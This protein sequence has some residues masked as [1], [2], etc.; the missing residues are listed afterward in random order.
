[1]S[2]GL[3]E[4]YGPRA[5]ILGA[6][7][8]LGVSFAEQLA[9]QGFDLTMVARNA[10]RLEAAAGQIRA[11]YR[12]DVATAVLDLTGDDIVARAD[13][14]IGSAEFGLVIYNAG[15]A[16]GI[17]SFIDGPLDRAMHLVKL[18][19]VAPVAFAHRALK[20]MRE[21]GRG[22]F[23]LMSSMSALAGSGVLAAYSGSKA[24]ET[25]FF[26]GLHWEMAQSGVDTLCVVAGLMDTPSMA[27]SG[28]IEGGAGG[29]VP[30]NPDGVAADA[31]KQLGH[32]ATIY[33][34][35]DAVIAAM[36]SAPRDGLVDAMT[37]QGAAL[38]G[39]EL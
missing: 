6:S 31:L 28:V 33:T 16:H 19:C 32:K 15:S 4:R 13:A 17:G 2:G 1:M 11:R 8:G 10:E 34:A 5:L 18:N 35:D 39:V 25:I 23:I 38:W 22:G 27:R 7:E 29:H 26:E 21:R 3:Y 12:V 9:E 14:L 36:R 24:F 37:R 20:P 30:L